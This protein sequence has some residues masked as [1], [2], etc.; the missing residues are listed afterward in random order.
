MAVLPIR[1]YGDPVLRDPATPVTEINGEL[2]KLIDDMVDTMYAAPGVGLAANQVG[3]GKRLLVIDLTVGEDPRQLHVM[4]NPEIIESEGEVTEEEGC[5]SIPDFVEIVTRPEKVKV[6]YLDR[7]GKER[8]MWGEGLM[9]RAICHE[10]DHLDGTL[11]VDYLRGMKKDRIIKKIQKLI[12][13]G[14]W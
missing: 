4:I 8:Q 10:I 7:H 12:K 5:L 14:S 2:Q 3:V 13:L 1:K 11:F 6:K 9:A